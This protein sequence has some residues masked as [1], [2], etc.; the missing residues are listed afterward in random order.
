MNCMCMKRHYFFGHFLCADQINK[1][2]INQEAILQL[3]V[4]LVDPVYSANTVS[5]STRLF[6]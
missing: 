6:C 4:N 2:R 3:F 5:G 1:G